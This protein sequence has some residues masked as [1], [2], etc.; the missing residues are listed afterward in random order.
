MRNIA[1]TFAEF[2]ALT[3]SEKEKIMLDKSQYEKLQLARKK[4]GASVM[5]LTT[6]YALDRTK[7]SKLQEWIVRDKRDFTDFYRPPQDGKVVWGNPG[8][9][10]PGML[11]ILGL[12]LPGD[13]SS[14]VT[15]TFYSTNQ[16]LIFGYT[17]PNATRQAALISNAI[18]LKENIFSDDLKEPKK[19]AEYL[20]IVKHYSPIVIGSQNDLIFI[21]PRA[22]VDGPVETA[23]A[24]RA[25]APKSHCVG[26]KPRETCVAIRGCGFTKEGGKRKPY[27]YRKPASSDSPVY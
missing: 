21:Y 2:K 19:K 16:T 3:K 4:Y 18:N 23:A 20:H 6:K 15:T 14:D 9:N 5:Y 13:K 8:E 10:L 17:Q 1:P 27:C 24:P 26:N 25:R 7:D 12:H 11:E 22:G